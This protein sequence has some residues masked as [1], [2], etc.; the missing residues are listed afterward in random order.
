MAPILFGVTLWR[1]R[2]NLTHIEVKQKI[3]AMYELHDATRDYVG[4]Y[5]VVFLI[6]RS[7]FVMITYALHYYPGLQVQALI[8]TTLLFICYIANVRFHEST[9]QHRIEI[10]NELILVCLCYHF[11]LFAD[12]MWEMSFRDHVGS[13]TVVFVMLLLGLNT[14]LI[15]IINAR[16]IKLKVKAKCAVFTAKKNK[17]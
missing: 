11:V 3:G 16:L 17:A 8:F 2:K 7:I 14:V 5:S 13:S 6:R 15:L 9:Q 4:T 1:N 10:V 12:Q